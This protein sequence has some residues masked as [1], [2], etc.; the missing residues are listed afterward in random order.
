MIRQKCHY[1]KFFHSFSIFVIFVLI[2]RTHATSA[3]HAACT[4]IRVFRIGIDTFVFAF[5]CNSC[6]KRH[7]MY[8]T[9]CRMTKII[10]RIDLCNF[11]APDFITD[12]YTLCE[13]ESAHCMSRCCGLRSA[14]RSISPTD[15]AR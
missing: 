10:N 1:G 9:V 3:L 2:N 5:A 13:E 14:I 6:I 11:Y 8:R 15:G 12:S 4:F 7:E